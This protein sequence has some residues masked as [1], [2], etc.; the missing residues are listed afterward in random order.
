MLK[1]KIAIEPV[2]MTD[3]QK[4]FLGIFETREKFSRR[5]SIELK[6]DR[7]RVPLME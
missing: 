4:N 7:P 3:F 5:K 6:K 1:S 2:L